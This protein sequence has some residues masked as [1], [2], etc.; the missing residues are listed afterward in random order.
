MMDEDFD[1]IEAQK[2]VLADQDLSDEFQIRLAISEFYAVA[3]NANEDNYDDCIEKLKARRNVI[4][5]MMRVYLAKFNNKLILDDFEKEM[6]QAKKD[7]AKKDDNVRDGKLRP[8][9]LFMEEMIVI[10]KFLGIRENISEK[11]S[12]QL[13]NAMKEEEKVGDVNG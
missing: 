10:G 6:K 9:P 11:L 13:L 4:L 2:Q 5:N 1:D 3:N 7:V 8:Y 12:E